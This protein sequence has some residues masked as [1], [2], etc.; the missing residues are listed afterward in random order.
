MVIIHCAYTEK[1]NPPGATPILTRDQIWKGLQ[2]K[3]RTPQDFLPVIESTD[4]L[5]DSETEVVRIA[6][7]RGQDGKPGREVKEV[8]FHRSDGALITNTIS[9]GESLSEHD[10]NLTYTF[11]WRHPDV[12]EGSHE[13]EKLARTNIEAAKGAVHS[14]I[15]AL[16]NMATQGALG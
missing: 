3:I 12:V 11:E 6:H 7:F 2:S 16:R 15:V 10:Y 8:D 9:D 1:I 14:S 5:E 4:V 13:H